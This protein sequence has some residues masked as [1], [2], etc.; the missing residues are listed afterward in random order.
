MVEVKEKEMNLSLLT[1]G[2]AGMMQDLMNEVCTA[3]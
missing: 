3:E 2:N 1:K